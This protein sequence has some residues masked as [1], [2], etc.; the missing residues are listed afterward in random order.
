MIKNEKQ[1]QQAREAVRNLVMILEKARK[2]Y[3]SDEY[4]VLAKP[5]LLELQQ[6]DNDIIQYLSLG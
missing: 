6:R 1:L 4:M 3:N 2:A 5:I